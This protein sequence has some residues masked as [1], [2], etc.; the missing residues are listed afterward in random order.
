MANYTDTLEALNALNDKAATTN[1]TLNS[2][3][4]ALNQIG[5]KLDSS[6]NLQEAGHA[7][8]DE[9]IGATI[10]VRKTPLEAQIVRFYIGDIE[11]KREAANKQLNDLVKDGFRPYI[12]AGISEDLARVVFVKY[13]Q[14]NTAE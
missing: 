10:D 11:S 6:N 2:I 9:I 12:T 14:P 7:K 1:S 13:K 3:L 5:T 4:N 8:M